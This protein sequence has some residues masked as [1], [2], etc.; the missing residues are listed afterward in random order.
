MKRNLL[1][2]LAIAAVAAA[3]HATSLGP[4]VHQW[5]GHT[6]FLTIKSNGHGSE[7]IDDGCCMHEIDLTFR[8]SNAHG[9]VR[10]GHATIEV[11]SVHLGKDWPKGQRAPHRGE[12]ATLRLH[13]HVLTEPLTHAYYCDAVSGSKGTC[14]A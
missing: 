1:A 12:T 7:W 5:V 14:G 10:R 9:T 2:A 8:V 3:A 6:R 11:L 13:N 4:F